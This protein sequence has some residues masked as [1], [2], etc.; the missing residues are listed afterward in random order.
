MWREMDVYGWVRPERQPTPSEPESGYA[1]KA[2]SA[3]MHAI[4]SLAE[5]IA[6][7][8]CCAVQAGRS[9]HCFLCTW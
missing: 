5:W 7:V 8:L 1:E 9:I 2:S 4:R 6:S 3:A